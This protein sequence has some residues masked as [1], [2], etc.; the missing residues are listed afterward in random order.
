MNEHGLLSVI[1]PAYNAARYLGQAI[2]SV[3]TQGYEPLELIVVD[4]GSTDITPEVVRG[5]PGVRYL[6]QPNGGIAAALNHGLAVAQGE[7]LAFCAAD[8]L[9][10]K[11]RLE[12]QFAAFARSPEPDI[13]FGHVQ[14]FFSPELGEEVTRRYYCP[15][16]PLPGYSLAAMHLRRTTFDRVGAFNPAYRI[17]E[18]VD[19]YARAKEQ[20]LSSVLLPEIVL[21]RRL[22]GQNLSIRTQND[23]ADFARILKASMDR[24]RRE[25]E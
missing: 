15:P 20:G 10:A 17:G 4:D 25:Q 14:N 21:S 12:N 23:R 2:E 13:V 19:W 6:Y 1:I 7:W 8:D 18:F 24:R 3:L 22:H 16:D 9:W 5:F 11:G